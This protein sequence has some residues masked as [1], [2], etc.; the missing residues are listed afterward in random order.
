MAESSEVQQLLDLA[1]SQLEAGDKQAA[2]ETLK[3]AT[4]LD[5]RSE[6]AWLL[7]AQA[8]ENDA[9]VLQCLER[10]VAVNPAN[11]DARQKV[12]WLRAQALLVEARRTTA[13]PTGPWARLRELNWRP[14]VAALLLLLFATTAY[15][16]G[17]PVLRSVLAAQ[18]TPLP[19]PTLGAVEMPPTWTSTPTS[20]ATP[21]PTW[22]NTPLPTYTP[23]VTSTPTRT[24]TRVPTPRPP[25]VYVPPSPTPVPPPTYRPYV[26]GCYHAGGTFAEGIVTDRFGAPQSGVHLVLSNSPGG[27]AKVSRYSGPDATHGSPGYYLLTID[28]SH[29]VP[30]TWYVWIVRPDGSV[31]SDPAAASFTTNRQGENSPSSCWR[32]EINFAGQ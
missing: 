22:T 20:T 30:G 4:A 13:A 17:Y 24:P 23:T 6:H 15:L 21:T 16:Y 27:P 26:M 2:R 7:R 25:P 28:P 9:E 32:A 1:G 18:T 12:D 3:R 19:H 5:P 29:S 10:A 31:A 14:I 8:A 11:L